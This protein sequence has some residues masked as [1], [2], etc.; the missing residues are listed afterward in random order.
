MKVLGLMFKGLLKELT[1]SKNLVRTATAPTES[2]LCFRQ[3]LFSQLLQPHLKNASCNFAHHIQQRNTWP[4]IT[5]TKVA[6]PRGGHGG[7]SSGLSQERGPLET[8]QLPLDR[9]LFPRVVTEAATQATCA[10]AAIG[11]CRA[12]HPTWILLSDCENQNEK[13]A[14]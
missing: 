7:C 13:S 14:R 12:N 6:L 2:T 9:K 11:S 3:F 8:H 5:T 1:G 4:V 10:K